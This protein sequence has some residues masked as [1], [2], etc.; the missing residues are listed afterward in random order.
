MKH[1]ESY[2]LNIFG[3]LYKFNNDN[4]NDI[5][6][7]ASNVVDISKMTILMDGDKKLCDKT[8]KETKFL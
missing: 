7:V 6:Y 5:K 4:P 3:R 8:Q 2:Y 1:R